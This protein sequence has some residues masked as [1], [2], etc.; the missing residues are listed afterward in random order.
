MLLGIN[1]SL[2]HARQID[3]LPIFLA[4]LHSAVTRASLKLV[5]LPPPFPSSWDYGLVPSVPARKS[6]KEKKYVI[7]VVLPA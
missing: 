7:W 6:V 2:E 1:K 4:C 3:A 5:I